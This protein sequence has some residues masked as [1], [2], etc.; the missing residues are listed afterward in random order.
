MQLGS[1]LKILLSGLLLVLFLFT[2]IVWRSSSYQPVDYGEYKEKYGEY[3]AYVLQEFQTLYVCFV[4]WI[5]KLT[6][7]HWVAA[8]TVVL[9]GVTIM[10]AVIAYRQ[11]EHF[12]L[13]ERAWLF[14]SPDPK[15]ISSS[16]GGK[17]LEFPVNIVNYGK[18]PGFVTEIW[19][20]ASATEPQ[21]SKVEYVD[22]K[23][24]KLDIVFAGSDGGPIHQHIF[25]AR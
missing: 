12:T 21:S 23:L 1:F 10:L 3:A 25:S 19:W 18:T 17:T 22:G 2:L 7:D 15:K 14:A 8:A 16:D 20:K 13:I 6:P 11:N 9:V 24:H 5:G 4:I